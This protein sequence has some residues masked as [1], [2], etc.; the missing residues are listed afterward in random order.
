[1]IYRFNKILILSLAINTPS[2]AFDRVTLDEDT[3]LFSAVEKTVPIIRSKYV[4]WGQGWQFSTAEVT[5]N[6]DTNG[7][8]YS[9]SSFSGHIQNLGINFSG[10]AKA[11]EREVSWVY[12]WDRTL[13][14]PQAIGFGIEFMLDLNA[15]TFSGEEAESPQLLSGKKGWKWTTPTGQS[16]E[17]TFS[18]ALADLYFER[19]NKNQIR[20]MFFEGLYKGKEQTTV[21]VKMSKAVSVLPPIGAKYAKPDSTWHESILPTDTSPIDLSFLNKNDLPAGKHGFI[22]AEK[23][24]LFFK[25]NTPVKFW[26]TNV[27]AYAL[28]LS[29]K[30]EVKLHAKRISKLGYNLVRIH[31]HDSGWVIPNVFKDQDTDTL[32]FSEESLKKIDWWVKCL[33]DEGI[34]LWIDLHVG[35]RFTV[36]DGINNFSDLARGGE[37]ADGRGFNYYNKDIES[38]M[39]AFNETYLTRVNT[40]T[41]LALKD[42]PAVI[43]M[44][45]TN[46]NDL[47]H[48]FG[49]ML[50]PDKNV[51]AHNAVF[52]KDVKSF[53]EKNE[54]PVAQTGRTWMMGESKIYLNDAEHRFNESMILPQEF[55]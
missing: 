6:H 46:E 16:V 8:K 29:S 19:G 52:S 23:D 25:D 55:W 9:G 27:Q 4:G 48:H 39:K 18:P 3:S 12:N 45:I 50:L 42:D 11:T 43:S 22:H 47:T 10:D 7:G 20:A 2:Y 14:L 5:S 40:Y 26:G 13:E 31:H 17:V 54:L 53:A 49:N 44:L 15:A 36:R 34:Y 37:Y 51:P 33:R 1:M 41:D 30:A 28:F 24:K 35:R 21:T 32:E 38:L